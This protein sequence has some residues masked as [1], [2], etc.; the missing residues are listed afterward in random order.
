MLNIF[1]HAFWPSVYLLWRSVFL[2]LRYLGWCLT[3]AVLARSE[4]GAWASLI[5]QKS[6]FERQLCFV[7]ELVYACLHMLLA[8]VFLTLSG[9]C[10]HSPYVYCLHFICCHCSLCSLWKIGNWRPCNFQWKIS[11]KI[12]ILVEK[13]DFRE[14]SLRL[15]GLWIQLVSMRMRVPSLALLSRLRIQDCQELWCSLAV[16]ARIWPLAWK[17]P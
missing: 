17:L 15:S 8:M 2:D 6:V 1:L 11:E 7:C 4:V 14:C 3:I 13:K 5:F 9:R 10:V 16:V 12:R